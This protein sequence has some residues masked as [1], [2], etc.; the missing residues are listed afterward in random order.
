MQNAT[1]A[2]IGAGYED[3]PLR[4]WMPHFSGETS[5]RRLRYIGP[6]YYRSSRLHTAYLPSSESPK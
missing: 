6:L 1:R 5:Y 2:L 3:A 4:L